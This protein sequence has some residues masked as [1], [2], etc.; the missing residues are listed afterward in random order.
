MAYASKKWCLCKAY[1][2]AEF[3]TSVNGIYG[4][5]ICLQYVFLCCLLLIGFTF[6]M[7]SGFM[8]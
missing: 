7:M 5:I 4:I 8:L 1:R 6:V 2:I 3:I